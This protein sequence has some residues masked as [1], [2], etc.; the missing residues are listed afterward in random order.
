MPFERPTLAAL[1]ARAQADAETRLELGAPLLPVSNVAIL[2][3]V[4]A[5][6]VHGLYGYLNWLSQQ[7]LP[8]TAEAEWLARHAAI[9]GLARLAATYATGAVSLTGT[10]GTV[11]PSATRLR[12]ADGVEF[13][14]MAAI[15]LG[16]D[17]S[18]PV[19]AGEPGTAGNAAATTALTLVNALAGVNANATV[20]TG[21]LTGGAAVESDAAL[22]ARLL[23]RIQAPPQ[24]GCARDYVA[25][26]YA[27]HPAITRAWVF[28]EEGGPGTV[29]V[30][31]MTDDATA[32]GTPAPAIVAAVASVIEA[33]RPV[34]ARVL[35]LAPLAAPLA[36]ALHVVPDTTAVRAAVAAAL[37]DLIRRETSPGGLLLI[38]HL[39]EVISTADG[40]TDYTMSSPSADVSAALGYITTLG[41]I[42]WV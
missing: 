2:S 42:T 33:L 23:T 13:L 37:A 32:D 5:G 38:S 20:A 16:T 12:R 29:T 40:V 19:I 26:T 35:V 6:A 41:T 17:A 10:A 3:R 27:A 14:T 24:G 22:R 31:M 21:G 39:R 1:A 18:A 15:T 30:R 9:W 25:W 4:L 28:P 34:T 8:D 11:V 7:V 36:V